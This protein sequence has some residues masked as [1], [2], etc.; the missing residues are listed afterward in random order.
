MRS[1]I[2]TLVLDDEE[3]IAGKVASGTPEAI[4]RMM[5]TGFQA[6]REGRFAGVDPLLAELLGREPRSVADQLA[7]SVA[8]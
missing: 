1:A 8:A 4:A 7:D 6:A 5:L 3:W 2:C